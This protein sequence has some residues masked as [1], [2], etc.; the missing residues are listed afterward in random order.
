MLFSGAAALV[1]QGAWVRLLGQSV[2]TSHEATATVLAAFFFG[3][4]L[5]AY[6]VERWL[7]KR[8]PSPGAYGLLELLLAGLG[9][10]LFWTLPR[11]DGLLV[12]APVLAEAG[13][14]RFALAFVLLSPP[15]ICMGATLPLI[16]ACYVRRS[17][18]LLPRLSALYAWN[19]FGAVLGALASGFWLIPSFGL[20]G[21]VHAAV[22]LNLAAALLAAFLGAGP[23][24][25]EAGVE[26]PPAVAGGAAPGLALVAL[27]TTGF[28]ALA[29]EVAWTRALGIVTGTT[30][31]GFAAILAAVLTG[32]ALGAAFARGRLARLRE[33]RE[34]LA[35]GLVVLGACLL[36]TR[37]G[38]AFLPGLQAWLR[39]LAGGALALHG[40]RYGTVFAL[41][42][43]PTLVLGALYPLSLALACGDAAG[44]RS[45]LG[46]AFA[47]NTFASIAGSLAAGF[48]LI[49]WLGTDR[50]LLL[51]ALVALLVPLALLAPAFGLS[52]RAR[53]ALPALALAGVAAGLPGLSLEDV[54]REV[55]YRREAAGVAVGQGDL[56][57]L[58]EGRGGVISVVS[59]DGRSAEVQNNGLKEALID[60][61][62]PRFGA[63]VEG[64]LGALPYLLHPDPRSAFVVGFGGGTTVHTLSFTELEEIHVVELE[65]KVV[66][67]VAL[68]HGGA[69][70]CLADPRVKL[71]FGDARSRLLIADARFDLIVSQP[72]HPWLAGAGNLFTREFFLLE[73][74]RLA[75]GGIV[76]QWV[77]LFRMEE[78][79]LRSIVST[80]YGV[81]PEGFMCI[82]AITGDLILI[83][84]EARPRLSGERVRRALSQEADLEHFFELHEIVHAGDLLWFFYCGRDSALALAGDATQNTDLNLY[85]EVR[86]ATLGRASEAEEE[87]SALLAK[88]YAL[89][90]AAYL[91]PEDAARTLAEA[92]RFFVSFQAFPQAERIQQALALAGEASAASELE[93]EILLRR[94]GAAPR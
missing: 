47:V 55:R 92:G 17:A 74:S 80:F 93:R 44:V 13:P 22:L 57:Y 10:L 79:V 66:E 70:P 60:R 37:A 72:S 25:V 46:R 48:W 84:S 43:L 73:K 39:T 59:Y 42:L 91:D 1:H 78:R 18:E 4:G 45:R 90:A 3:L 56:L 71:A 76:A 6:L 58:G 31:F 24:R 68:L 41:V 62:N 30:L 63:V 82:N 52:S 89:D 7:R 61:E 12:R 36:A 14:L 11:L 29:C 19:T 15:A 85:S 32:I 64:L 8:A 40:V 83:G 23:G 50:T 20:S 5:G 88:H 21:A 38:F 16:A 77:N 87:L 86:L 34:A 75:P 27:A 65:P 94:A 28:L 81:F 33:P 35:L 49:P 9:L 67:A 54:I 26:E 51:L 53:V 2:G 69:I